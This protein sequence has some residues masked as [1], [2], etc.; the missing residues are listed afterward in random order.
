MK[1]SKPSKIGILVILCL[2]GLIWGINFLKGRDIFRTEKVFYARYKNVG[3]LTATTLVT[4]NGL[5]IGYVREIYFAEDL[6][7][8][9]IVKIALHN[10]FPI[11]K[12]TSAQIAS[13][14][15]LGSKVV[16]LNLGHSEKILQANDTLAS[17][18]DADLMQQVNEQIAP[19]KAKA[20]RLIENLDSIVSAASKFLNNDSQRN[21][22]ESIRQ[23]HSTMNNLESLTASLNE[24]VT[25]QKKNLSSTLSNIND[26]SGNLKKNSGKLEHMITNFSTFSDSLSKIE[27]NKTV[28]H[29]NGSVASLSQILSKIDTANGTIGLLIKDPKLYQNITSST[30]SLNQL[31]I[32]LRT[33]PK[34]YV[35]FSA[36][37]FGKKSSP[38]IPEDSQIPDNVKF[39]V[40]IC[41]SKT[42][43]P[44]TTPL[45]NEVG[46]VFETKSG[47][48]FYYFTGPFSS[49]TKLRM[50]LNKAQGAFPEAVLKCYQNGKEITFKKVLKLIKK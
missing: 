21:I 30:E 3:G 40:R 10:N 29:I 23:I 47:D 25:G 16:K 17:Q 48:D 12:G 5:K 41:I 44:L 38:S 32:D 6:S 8:D 33:N 22:S 34:K 20:E 46:P 7:G 2:T 24:I 4:L 1:L 36:I 14:D 28:E 19:I 42:P 49:Y 43:I 35:H 27:L 31:L 50:I 15:F 18:M 39:K 37:D 13:S 9:L 26:I 45:F 11:P